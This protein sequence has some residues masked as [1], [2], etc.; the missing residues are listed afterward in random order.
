MAL[1]SGPPTHVPYLLLSPFFKGDWTTWFIQRRYL[2]L[3][4]QM[5]INPTVCMAKSLTTMRSWGSHQI[6][7]QFM[8]PAPSVIAHIFIYQNQVLQPHQPHHHLLFRGI[9]STQFGTCSTWT[10]WSWQWQQDSKTVEATQSTMS[11]QFARHGLAH[12]DEVSVLTQHTSS[13]EGIV[14]LTK[15]YFWCSVRTISPNSILYLTTI[16]CFAIQ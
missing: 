7:I 2:R 4:D 15:I 5:D 3:Y 8:C 9:P 1:L 12:V 10:C 6:N 11:G 16:Y 13:Q 14:D